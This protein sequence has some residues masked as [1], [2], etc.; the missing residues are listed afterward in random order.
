M[1]FLGIFLTFLAAM[2]GVVATLRSAHALV[3]HGFT[4]QSQVGPHQDMQR[5]KCTRF[6]NFE[7]GFRPKLGEMVLI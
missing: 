6:T 7:I 4:V 5:T 2:P 1:Q 3:R